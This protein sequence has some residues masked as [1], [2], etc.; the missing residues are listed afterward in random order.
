MNVYTD[1]IILVIWIIHLSNVQKPRC[2]TSGTFIIHS[3][4][5][6]MWPF[7]TSCKWNIHKWTIWGNKLMVWPLL[8]KRLKWFCINNCVN[9]C[10]YLW[11]SRMWIL[12]I[13][14]ILYIHIFLRILTAQ[15]WLFWGLKHTPIKKNRVQSPPSFGG[16]LPHWFLVRIHLYIKPRMGIRGRPASFW[17]VFFH[18]SINDFAH[19]PWE[20]GPPN[21]PKKKEFLHKLL[22]K[23]PGVCGWDLRII[24]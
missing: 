3:F 21:F 14:H 2:F 9:K 15:E 11:I 23:L 7:F 4:T 8:R 19:I 5:Y 13:Y 16:F 20:D 12:Y 22:V 18:Q 10:F 17:R 24:M 6:W 1:S